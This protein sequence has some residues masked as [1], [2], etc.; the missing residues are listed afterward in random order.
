MSTSRIVNFGRDNTEFYY[1]NGRTWL[2]NKRNR[3]ALE[4]QR[5]RVRQVYA[6]AFSA[7]MKSSEWVQGLVY[8][9]GAKTLDELKKFCDSFDIV[10]KEEGDMLTKNEEIKKL[11]AEIQHLTNKVSKLE[12]GR[13]GKEPANGTVFKIEKK[14]SQMGPRYVYAA[15]R[16][17]G[18]W[19]LTGTS[20]AGVKQYDWEELKSF[21]GTHSRVWSMTTSKELVD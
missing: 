4:A 15:V 1:E 21:I 18:A 19:Y 10:W 16:A 20:G 8:L 7:A 9:E 3:A 6:R 13:M 11:Q 14:Y 5:E 17:D 2:D 12:H